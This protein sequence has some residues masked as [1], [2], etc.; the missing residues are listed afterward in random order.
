MKYLKLIVCVQAVALLYLFRENSDLKQHLI[1]S[2]DVVSRSTKKIESLR[3]AVDT[4]RSR[5]NSCEY[6][7]DKYRENFN[8]QSQDANGS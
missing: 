3:D 5:A 8:I 7:L 2:A 6:T 4:E 1:D